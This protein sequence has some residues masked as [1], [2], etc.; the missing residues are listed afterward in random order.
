MQCE[1]SPCTAVCPVGATYRTADGVVLIDEERCIGCGYCVV[2]C[3]YGARYIVPADG[4]TPRGVA[5]VADKCTFCYHRI[6]V[7]QSPA[8]VVACPVG[9]RMFGDLNDPDSEV[10]VTLSD[11]P[12]DDPQAR[13]R[14]EAPGPLHRPRGRGRLMTITVAGRAVRLSPQ[15]AVRVARAEVARTPRPLKI[16]YAL[17]VVLMG[18][19]AVGALLTIAPGTEVF[20]T[21]PSFEWGLLISAYVFFA[22]TT[23]GLCLGSSL[24]TVFGIEMF[25]PLE[26]RHAILAVLSLTT[27][28]GII[29]LD[30]HYPVRM[31][32]GAVFNPS[33]SS[34]MWWMGAFYAVY[35]VFL[36]VEVWSMFTHHDEVHRYACLASSCTAVLAPTTLGAVFGVVL[37]RS[38]WYGLFTPMTML[39]TALL[40][41]S[42]V[43]GI[44][45]VAVV[46]FE[47]AGF[48]R[49]RRLA[50][51]AI[52]ILL[53]VALVGSIALLAR[54]L[55]SGLTSDDRG[56][57]AATTALVSGPLAVGFWARVIA[58]L[59][60]PLVLIALPVTRTVAGTGIA[61]G[62]VF[63]GVFLDR[64]LFVV[65]GQMIPT[66]AVGGVVSIDYVAYTPSLVEISIVVAAFAFIAF[67]YTLAERYLDLR[68]SDVHLGYHLPRFVGTTREWLASRRA[69]RL[70]DDVIDEPAGSEP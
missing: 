49:A 4:E 55:A 13:A 1:N 65:A 66:T 8:C 40:A 22:I 44:V 3:P 37:S 62:L 33:L 12:D 56:L 6:T 51:P 57:L 24:G 45:F 7:G 20:G 63:V 17:L 28:F 50:L 11:G 32:F 64:L 27:A 61:A 60:I 19:G 41:G 18:L 30:L 21:T 48:E 70:A 53:A 67:V 58:G 39:V 31:V 16:W 15:S 14:D 59:L 23:S 2:A 46:H 36:L 43:L 68:E 34:P 35:L 5:G 54:S 38:Y 25:R 10:S 26:K 47:L 52:R 69:T 29:A 42:A 9:A